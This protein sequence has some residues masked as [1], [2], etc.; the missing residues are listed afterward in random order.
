MLSYVPLERCLAMTLPEALVAFSPQPLSCVSLNSWCFHERSGIQLYRAP[1]T[2]LFSAVVRLSTCP[3]SVPQLPNLLLTALLLSL[4]PTI[5]YLCFRT[6][7]VLIQHTPWSV[8][9]PEAFWA[10]LYRC[11][12]TWEWS[13]RVHCENFLAQAAGEGAALPEHQVPMALVGNSRAFY[14]QLLT[15]PAELKSRWEVQGV[16][17]KGA[18]M[19]PTAWERFEKNIVLAEILSN[20]CANFIANA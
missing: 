17:S 7:L 19:H 12:T 13:H 16:R 18:S 6:P 20:V 14:R 3:R 8:L 11:C 9:L 15:Q 5:S 10:F 2:N 1:G 4:S